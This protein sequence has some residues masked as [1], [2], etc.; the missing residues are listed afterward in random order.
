VMERAASPLVSAPAA[1]RLEAP[2]LAVM[3]HLLAGSG[4]WRRPP[5]LRRPTRY[6]PRGVPRAFRAIPA[7]H[8]GARERGI[9]PR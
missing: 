8:H 3:C 2:L 4:R 6:A 9:R 5:I 7:C 1:E